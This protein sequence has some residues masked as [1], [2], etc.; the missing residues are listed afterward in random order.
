MALWQEEGTAADLHHSQPCESKSLP[1]KQADSPLNDSQSPACAVERVE[2]A[3][4]A[5]IK[6]K[7]VILWK[8]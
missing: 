6:A 4:R 1:A 2:V 7:R 5:K 3:M 8:V